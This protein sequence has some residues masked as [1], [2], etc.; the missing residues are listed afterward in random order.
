MVEIELLLSVL[1][2]QCLERRI[3]DAQTLAREIE[4]WEQERNEG[5]ATV[6]SGA[7]RRRTLGRSWRAYTQS[8]II[9]VE[10]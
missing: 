3:P 5:G 4:A 7:S 9:V 8:R 6:H 2:R 10:Y 1:S